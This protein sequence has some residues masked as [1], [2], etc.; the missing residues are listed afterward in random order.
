M[1]LPRHTKAQSSCSCQRSEGE[2]RRNGFRSS[3]VD[4]PSPDQCEQLAPAQSGW[5]ARTVVSS[6]PYER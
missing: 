6:A 3:A 5:K 1:P 4:A 2:L